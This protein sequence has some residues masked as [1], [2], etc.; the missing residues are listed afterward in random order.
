MKKDTVGIHQVLIVIKSDIQSKCQKFTRRHVD[1]SHTSF[2]CITVKQM[3][4]P[5]NELTFNPNT[6]LCSR[7]Q[8]NRKTEIKCS[9]RS[10]L[11]G[12]MIPVAKWTVPQLLKSDI[13]LPDGDLIGDQV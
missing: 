5:S 4:Y 3:Q 9:T 11:S 6:S 13:I 2:P 7:K 12:S 10:W 1:A 8:E